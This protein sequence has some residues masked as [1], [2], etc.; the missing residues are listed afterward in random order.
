MSLN[1]SA[2]SQ[3]LDDAIQQAEA[4][5]VLVVTSRQRRRNRDGAV[6]PRLGAARAQVS[7]S[8]PPTARRARARLGVRALERRHRRARRRI[9]T[10]DLGGRFS[11]R[12]GTS[13]A[14]GLRDRSGGAPGRRAPD[15]SATSLRAALIASSRRGGRVDARVAGGELDCRRRAPAA[16]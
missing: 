11:R 14:A 6:L 12:S 10:S 16:R 8:R 5:G 7:P 13:F 3:A 15:A 4:R 1:G 2:R 9:L